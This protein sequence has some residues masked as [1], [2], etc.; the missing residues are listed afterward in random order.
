MFLGYDFIIVVG[1]VIKDIFNWVFIFLIL[2]FYCLNLLFKIVGLVLL[3]KFKCSLMGIWLGWW[4]FYL[5]NLF[6]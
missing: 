3:S 4:F 6:I 5:F 1:V 2:N